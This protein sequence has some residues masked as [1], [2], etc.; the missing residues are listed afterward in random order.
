MDMESVSIPPTNHFEEA[1]SIQFSNSTSHSPS[2]ARS[3]LRNRLS[4]KRKGRKTLSTQTPK[5]ASPGQ[6]QLLNLDTILQTSPILPDKNLDQASTDTSGAKLCNSLE[7]IQERR[8]KSA[9]VTSVKQRPG[10]LSGD[11]VWSSDEE[12][13]SVRLVR[14]LDDQ[15]WQPGGKL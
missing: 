4:L 14:R 13:D 12:F 9:R 8:T 11:G 2:P 1:T 3:R 10:F 5:L 7:K 6:Q 15:D